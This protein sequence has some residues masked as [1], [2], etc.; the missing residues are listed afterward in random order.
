MGPISTIS[1]LTGPGQTGPRRRSASP[2]DP[3]TTAAPSRLCSSSY[4]PPPA[5][6]AIRSATHLVSSLARSL[7]R[8]PARSVVC[9]LPAYRLILTRGYLPSYND[10]PIPTCP[11]LPNYM[12][13]PMHNYLHRPT[14]TYLHVPTHLYILTCVSQPAYTYLPILTWLYLTYIPTLTGLCHSTPAYLQLPT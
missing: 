14:R 10:L 1:Y 7:A 4:T 8:L 13:L 11:H 12:Y 9:S 3:W 5:R 6:Q 2:A